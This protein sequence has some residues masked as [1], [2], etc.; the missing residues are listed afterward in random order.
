MTSVVAKL[1]E[2]VLQEFI[3]NHVKQELIVREQHGF[4]PKSYMYHQL[5]TDIDHECWTDVLNTAIYTGDAID[6]LYLDFNIMHT[7]D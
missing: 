2:S 6:V 7:I 1:F 3:I 4:L 5:L